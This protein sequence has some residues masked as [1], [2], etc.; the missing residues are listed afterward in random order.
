MKSV[1]VRESA[2]RQTLRGQTPRLAEYLDRSEATGDGTFVIKVNQ[3]NGNPILMP[4]DRERHPGIPEGW[5]T[6]VAN[7]HRYRGN[8]E[9]TLNAAGR[10]GSPGKNELP[11]LLRGWF[12]P[13]AGAPGTRHQVRLA[14]EGDD[15]TMTPVGVGVLAPVLWKA[16]AREQIPGLFGLEFN[17]SV[18]QQGFVRRGDKTFL[19]VTL[20]KST[21]AATHKYR[22]HFLSAGEFEW[23][24]QN[25]TSRASK[26][27][28]SIRDHAKLGIEVMLFIRKQSK[29][30]DG[31]ASP[32]VYCGQVDFIRWDDDKPITVWWKLRNEVPGRLHGE[33]KVPG[34]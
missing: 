30:R 19:L 7:G 16:Y 14:K 13:S 34:A 33:L 21:A 5:S 6:F 11:A 26:P 18:W 28:E 32:F 17:T 25:Q 10:D 8:F 9:N 22:D 20:D 31:K 29:T 2:F 3:A 27:G 24:S 4:F 12:G 15:W 1:V 23:Q